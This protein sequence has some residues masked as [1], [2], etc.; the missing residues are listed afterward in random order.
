MLRGEKTPALNNLEE[1]YPLDAMGKGKGGDRPLTPV[2]CRAASQA[3]LE[4][5]LAVVIPYF[6]RLFP[7]RPTQ[8]TTNYVPLKSIHKTSLKLKKPS[9]NNLL[10]TNPEKTIP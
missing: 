7:P 2:S 3:G 5:S 10:K 8:K 9:K 4:F 6:L 1:D